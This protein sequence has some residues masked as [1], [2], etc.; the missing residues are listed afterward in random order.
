MAISFSNLE[1]SKKLCLFSVLLSVVNKIQEA[2][3]EIA[4]DLNEWE[5]VVFC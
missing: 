5:T 4:P 1:K 2:R 3:E